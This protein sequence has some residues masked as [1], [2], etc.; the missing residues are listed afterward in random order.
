MKLKAD[1]DHLPKLAETKV[2]LP[3]EAYQIVSLLNKTLKERG[4]VFGL[5]KDEEGYY[6]FNIYDV[7]KENE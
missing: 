2:K 5:A 4:L 1:H 3:E 7:H 6:R